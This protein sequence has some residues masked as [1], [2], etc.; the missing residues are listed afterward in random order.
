MG[1][2]QKASPL[3]FHWPKVYQ[4]APTCHGAVVIES[5]GNIYQT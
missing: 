4:I 3:L 5:G 1:Y 2:I